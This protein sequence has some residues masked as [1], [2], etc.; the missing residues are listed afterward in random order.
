MNPHKIQ[1]M[2]MVMISAALYGLIP[3]MAHY[4]TEGGLNTLSLLFYRY[5]FAFIILAIM[6][7]FIPFR[8]RVT[9]RQL[10]LF[11]IGAV[12]GYGF[13]AITLF[14]SY[15]YISTGLA[16]T[17]HFIYPTMAIIFAW[18]IYH[19]TVSPMKMLALL[20]S[21]TGIFMLTLPFNGSVNSTG[22][23]LALISGVF[24]AICIITVA[25]PLIRDISAPTLCFYTF[26][27]SSLFFLM[28]TLATKQLVWFPTMQSFHST[29]QLS[30]WPTIASVWLFYLGMKHIGTGSAA[31]LSTFEPITSLLIGILL[32]HEPVGW[33]MVAGSFFILLSVI[34]I[35]RTKNVSHATTSQPPKPSKLHRIPSHEKHINH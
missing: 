35:A 29:I 14:Q 26:L 8:L 28:I 21:L 34:M 11:V 1:G 16:T 15:H 23:L 7:I 13:T 5:S 6:R 18:L 24:Y 27:F 20:S 17:L 30:L 12:V 10:L 4:A 3:M 19:E 31:I 25:H 2:I 33:R 9:S 32:F 22:I